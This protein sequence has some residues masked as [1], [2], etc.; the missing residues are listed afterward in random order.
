MQYKV[1]QFNAIQQSYVDKI[2]STTSLRSTV[3]FR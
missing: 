3:T 2:V 1:T